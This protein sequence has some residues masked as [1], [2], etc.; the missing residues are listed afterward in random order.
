VSAPAQR[1]LRKKWPYYCP[2]EHLTL[3]SLISIRRAV[4]ILGGGRYELR[5]INV[6]YSLRYLLRFLRIPIL[7]PRLADL[8]LPIPSGA[9]E[10]YWYN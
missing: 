10:L 9:F 6:H 3:P 8:L 4:A 7:I 5:R 1:I 2:D